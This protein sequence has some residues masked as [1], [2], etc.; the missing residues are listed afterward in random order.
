MIQVYNVYERHFQ[1]QSQ[2]FI[3]STMD[4]YIYTMQTVLKREMYWLQ[5]HQNNRLLKIVAREK[6]E[7]II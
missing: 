1:I 3:E 5:S 6:N 4:I 2:R 7:Y